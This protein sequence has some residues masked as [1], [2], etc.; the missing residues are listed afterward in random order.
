MKILGLD[1]GGANT[2]YALLENKQKEDSVLCYDSDFFPIWKQYDNYG[3][4]LHSLY[5][6]LLEKF[7]HID[8]IVSVITAELAD[9]FETKKEGITKISKTIDKVFLEKGLAKKALI[10]SV[11]GRFLSRKKAISKWMEVAAANWHA[12]A[13]YIGLLYPNCIIIDI[14]STTTDIIPVHRGNIVSKGRNDLTRLQ[15]SELVYTGLLRTNVATIVSKISLHSKE[16]PVASELFATTGDV[17]FILGEIT[18]KEF[19]TETVNNKPI[20]KNYSSNRLARIICADTNMLN[21]E[22]ICDI[23]RQIKEQQ[24]TKIQKALRIVQN[25]YI[26]DYKFEPPLVLVGSGT[27]AIGIPL[28]KK[29]QAKKWTTLTDKFPKKLL[30]ILPAFA[31]AK[32]FIHQKKKKSKLM[33]YK[34]VEENN[35]L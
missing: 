13:K 11:S 19:T 5:K 1:I 22:D 20:T 9:C 18:K 10:Y 2:K 26:N 31:V 32:L 27:Q 33:R 35:C 34:N 15:N 21:A 17:Y 16:I 25:R 28:M 12:A 14:G 7:T 24:F 23:A 4:Y 3:H 30:E 8:V 6:K 29:I